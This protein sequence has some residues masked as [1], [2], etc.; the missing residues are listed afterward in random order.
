VQPNVGCQEWRKVQPR[1][2]CLP[3]AAAPAPAPA[4]LSP[5]CP[6]SPLSPPSHL[7]CW[8]LDAPQPLPLTL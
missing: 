7:L 4:P 2:P 5:F 3:C 6:L 8:P 1:Y